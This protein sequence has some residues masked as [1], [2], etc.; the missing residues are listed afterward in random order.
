MDAYFRKTNVHNSNV[1]L[2][3]AKLE[4]NALGNIRMCVYM[5]VQ[6]LL[7]EP[8]T[9]V[10]SKGGPLPVSKL[11]LCICNQTTGLHIKQ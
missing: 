2:S 1:L 7:F 9:S 3:T 6:A 10:L 5:F 4:D 8:L 11:C